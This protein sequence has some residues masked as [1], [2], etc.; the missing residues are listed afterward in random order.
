ME[1]IVAEKAIEPTNEDLDEMPK[2]GSV[3]ENG[4]ESQLKSP[5]IVLLYNS[6]NNKMELSFGKKFQ[7]HGRVWPYAWLKPQI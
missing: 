7:W 5:E 3:D 4:D 2:Q 1:E 6:Q